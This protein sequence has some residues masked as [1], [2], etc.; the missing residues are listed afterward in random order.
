ML[1]SRVSARLTTHVGRAAPAARAIRTLGVSKRAFASA[2]PK[3]A[4][5]PTRVFDWMYSA[6]Q[7]DLSQVEEFLKLGVDVGTDVETKKK[8][9]QL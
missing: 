7:G 2:S 5:D 3:V 6:S 4:N 8:K 9:V 1:I